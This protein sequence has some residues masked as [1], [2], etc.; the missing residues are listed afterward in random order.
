MPTVL[1]HD[2]PPSKQVTHQVLQMVVTY[3]TD[4]SMLAVPPSNPL[5]NV[6]RWTLPCEVDL[7]LQ[8]I[9][10]MPAAPVEL[11]VAYD[12]MNPTEAVGFLLYLPVPTHPDACGVTYMAVKQS[13]RRRGFGTAMMRQAI[14][15]YP[16]VELTC[17]VKKVPFYE[18]LGF[19]VIDS[20]NTQVVMNTRSASTTGL[21]GI[22]DVAPIYQ[23]PQA[24][25]IH[26]QLVNRW[27]IKVMANAEKQLQR[28]ADQLARQAASYVRERL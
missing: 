14:A 20:E 28:H 16:H 12:D 18:Q 9:G 27:G 6:Y 1:Y 5:Y 24:K 7:Y 4:L 25:E 19:Q 26:A 13:H 3:L 11:I 17:P 15:R 23:S 21:M 2:T 10:Q 22:V 8:R